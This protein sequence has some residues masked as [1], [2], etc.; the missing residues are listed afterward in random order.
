MEGR[1]PPTRLWPWW[2]VAL[3]LTWAALA[4]TASALAPGYPLCAFRRLTGLP[5]PTCGTGRAVLLTAG[6]DPLGAFGLN[7]LMSLVGVLFV[8]ESLAR[9]FFG[10][11]LLPRPGA[12]W[13]FAP[14]VIVVAVA[15]NW[16][17]VLAFVR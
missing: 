9:L 17:Y 13:R 1:A 6:G 4:A 3:V 5:C 16:A 2:A 14:V 8:A 15:L 12:W 11:G 10:R 7:P